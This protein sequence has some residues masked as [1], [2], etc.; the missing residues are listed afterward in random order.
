VREVPNIVALKDATAD[1][2]AA[3]HLVAE[4][5]DGFDLYSGDDPMTLAFLAV[6]GVGVVGTSTHWTGAEMG[7][8]IAAF[9][10]GDIGRARE[11]NALL[12]ESFSFANSDEVVFTMAIKAMLR[13]LGIPVGECRLPLPPTPAGVEDRARQ[14][15]ANLHG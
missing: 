11:I 14:V 6:G 10:K 9:E 4:L 2:P 13:T 3:A 7:E 12:Y 1:P 5:G 15:Y 8:M